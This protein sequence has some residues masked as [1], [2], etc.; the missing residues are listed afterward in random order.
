MAFPRQKLQRIFRLKAKA[1]KYTWTV[2]IIQMALGVTI[3][4]AAL[5]LLSLATDLTVPR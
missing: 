5:L 4:C 3:I 2:D 1:R